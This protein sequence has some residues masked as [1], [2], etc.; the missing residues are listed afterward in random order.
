MPTPKLSLIPDALDLAL[1]A[2]DGVSIRLTV[3]DNADATL[4]VDGEI[5]AQI[6]RT[7]SDVEVMAEFGADLSSGDTGIIFLSLT[8]EQT[9]S[10]IT[11]K[12][13][14][15]GVWDVQWKKTDGEPTTLVQGKVECDADVTR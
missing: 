6:R 14:F 11:D 12:P 1:Y 8:G 3:T 4:P 9:A 13:V 15:K 7:K 10:L 5:T 2:G